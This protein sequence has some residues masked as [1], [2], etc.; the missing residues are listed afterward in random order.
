MEKKNVHFGGVLAGILVDQVASFVSSL[1]IGTIYVTSNQ[2]GPSE[3]SKVYSDTPMLIVYLLVGLF[4]TGLGGYVS[5]SVAKRDAYFHASI[6][7]VVG[8]AIGFY[9]SFANFEVPLWYHLIGFVAVIPAALLGG[10]AAF[11]K[12]R[13]AT[14]DKPSGRSAKPD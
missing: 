1:L 11:L 5:A 10:H 4:C 9:Y 12:R 6:I 3:I 2:I 14:P 7:G 8:A 13:R